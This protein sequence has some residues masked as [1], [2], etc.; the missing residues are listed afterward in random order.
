MPLGVC[1]TIPIV[2]ICE[3]KTQEHE[4]SVFGTQDRHYLLVAELRRRGPLNLAWSISD[5]ALIAHAQTSTT[6][7]GRI[8]CTH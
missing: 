8:G 5:Q 1:R 6:K 4:T 2:E 7:A 3:Q